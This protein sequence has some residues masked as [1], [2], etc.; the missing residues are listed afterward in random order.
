[1]IDDIT[2]HAVGTV[3]T[4]PTSYS[5]R[6]GTSFDLLSMTPT[7]SI[8]IS[9]AVTDPEAV[10]VLKTLRIG[11]RVQVSGHPLPHYRGDFTARISM[12][13]REIKPL[14]VA[15]AGSLK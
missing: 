2:M 13:A 10:K 11:S 9:T 3:Q 1:L 12:I 14:D 5:R 8:M 7:G 15:T 4:S 6:D